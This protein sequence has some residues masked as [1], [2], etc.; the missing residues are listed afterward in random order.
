VRVL[1]IANPVAGHGRATRE[2]T[3]VVRA[4]EERGHRVRRHRTRRRGDA[5]SFVKKVQD[6]IDRI[7][8]V[9]GDGTLNEVLNGLDDP[10]RIPITTMG[11]GTANLLAA[12]L[13]IPTEPEAVADLVDRGKVHRIDLGR[14]GDHRFLD[15]VSSG[16]DAMVTE[17]IR[18]SRTGT[19]GF[20]GY[21]APIVRTVAGYREPVLKVQVDRRKPLVGALAVVSNFRNYGGLFHITDR[22]RCDSGHLDVCVFHRAAVPHLL[23]YAFAG[24][25]GGVSRLDGVAYRTGRRIRIES[26]EPVAV[27]VDG[28]YWG[29]TPVTIEM[30]PQSVPILVPRRRRAGAAG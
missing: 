14:I 10:T 7:V 19:L 18:A 26:H 29:T 8:V 2:A 16:F 22:A 24:W 25:R 5:R 15:V 9:G 4:L 13:G 6:E 11:A 12:E 30:E 21:A 27:Q 20:A 23:L 3:R 28:D 17:A 1:V